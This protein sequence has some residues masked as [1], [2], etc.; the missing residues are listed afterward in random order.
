MNSSLKANL[1]IR[2][3]YTPIQPTINMSVE[4][5]PSY[6]EFLPHELLQDY[7]YC[8]WELKTEQPLE[9]PFTYRAVTDGCIDIFME[10]HSPRENLVMGFCKKFTEFPLEHSFHYIGIR[11]LPTMFP[12]FFGIDA[13]LLSDRFQHLSHVAPG[14][15]RS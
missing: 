9:T 14:M 8:Y 5:H 13:S 2:N 4:A 11:F 6:K 1:N 7:I 12:Q 3:L 10:L 15:S